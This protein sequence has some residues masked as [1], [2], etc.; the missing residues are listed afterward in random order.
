MLVHFFCLL[1]FKFKFEFFCLKPFSIKP[2]NS[3]P[4]LFPLLPQPISPA[5]QHPL[6]PMQP[7]TRSSPCSLAGPAGQPSGRRLHRQPASMRAPAAQRASACQ[8]SPA[9]PPSR[10]LPRTAQPAPP[11]PAVD[12]RR[13]PPVIPKLRPS[14]PRTP[15][16][17]PSPSEARL[18]M[19]GPHAKAGSP[20]YL[21]RPP[22]LEPPTRA[23]TPSPRAAANPSRRHLRFPRRRRLLVAVCHPRAAQEG[24]E[25]SCAFCFDAEHPRSDLAG[26][27]GRAAASSRRSAASPPQSSSPLA[28]SPCAL[29]IGASHAST[30]APE[31]KIE[32]AGESRRRPPLPPA[33]CRRSAAGS[34]PQPPD[35][36]PA[37]RIQFC[38]P[39]CTQTASAVRSRSN[40]SKSTH[41]SQLG[42]NPA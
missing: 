6:Q 13:G 11:P 15:L 5:A 28:L 41:P 37:H 29:H 17:P 14:P 23:Q 26:V 8:A 32:L 25:P 20:G 9:R 27:R 19:R 10:F 18:P 22:P 2:L 33:V 38:R 35:Q 40:G 39:R 7:S 30:C 24:R 16:P 31:P 12:D 34:P 42:Q 4:T 21:S 36:D 3:Y 1:E